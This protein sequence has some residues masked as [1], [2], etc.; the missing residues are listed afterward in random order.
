M[1]VFQR[2]RTAID[3][4]RQRLDSAAFMEG[5]EYAAGSLL[6]SNSRTMSSLRTQAEYR[7]TKPMF[8][9]GIRKACDVW[10]GSQPPKDT[11]L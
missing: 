8:T 4:R 10:E 11:P 3:A 6:I 2:L 5:F 7:C 9:L 1:S